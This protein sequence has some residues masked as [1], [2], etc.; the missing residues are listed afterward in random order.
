MTINLRGPYIEAFGGQSATINLRG[1][2]IEA[3]GGQ[4][5]TINLRGSNSIFCIFDIF[6]P[7]APVPNGN[8]KNAKPQFETPKTQKI[9]DQ[10]SDHTKNRRP[11]ILQAHYTEIGGVIYEQVTG[12]RGAGT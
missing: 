8:V 3:F 7:A 11:K 4:S 6:R 2:Y 12:N 10:K 5:A 1:A 9:D